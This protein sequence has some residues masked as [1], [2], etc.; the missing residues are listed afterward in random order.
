MCSTYNGLAMMRMYVY[1]YDVVATGA[2]AHL[3][4]PQVC[5]EAAAGQSQRVLENVRQGLLDADIRTAN[6]PQEVPVDACI[7]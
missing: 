7:A 2:R 4:S 5:S 3:L 1:M 6:R